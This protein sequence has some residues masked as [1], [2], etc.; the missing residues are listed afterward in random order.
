LS[1]PNVITIDGYTA[2]G[3]GAVSSML[4]TQLG[5]HYLESG[6]LYRALGWICYHH[7]IDPTLEEAVI[8]CLEQHTLAITCHHAITQ[9][10]QNGKCLDNAVLRSEV[11]SQWASQA[12]VHASVR[13][14]LLTQQLQ[15]RQWPGLVAEGRDMSAIFPDAIGRFFLT[16]DADVR[17]KRRYLQLQSRGISVNIQDVSM[18]LLERDHRDCSRVTSPVRPMPGV[19]VLNVTHTSVEDIVQNIRSIINLK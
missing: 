11:V 12:S 6:L 9:C 5:W 19:S 3:K 1:I 7:V 15:A 16:A 13:R 17:I 8:Q 4:A 2:T 10:Y 18:A 14:L